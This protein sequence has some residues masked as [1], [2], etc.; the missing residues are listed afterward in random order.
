MARLVGSGLHAGMGLPTLCQHLVEAAQRNGSHDDISALL[1]QRRPWLG[2]ASGYWLA[3]LAGA[4]A[5]A[6]VVGM[7]IGWWNWCMTPATYPT[8]TTG[9][10]PYPGSDWRFLPGLRRGH[11]RCG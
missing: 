9:N 4:V 3:L 5:G 6:R 8:P 10:H 11:P 1:V 2:V 7:I